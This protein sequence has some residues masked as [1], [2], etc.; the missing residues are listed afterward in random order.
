MQ[1]KYSTWTNI[2]FS[3]AAF[4]QHKSCQQG[5]RQV[6]ATTVNEQVQNMTLVHEENASGFISD[7]C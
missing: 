7:Q 3:G 5:K 6:A 2:T 4:G 1:Q